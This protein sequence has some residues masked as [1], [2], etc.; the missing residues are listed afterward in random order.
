MT[1]SEF[2]LGSLDSSRSQSSWHLGINSS[3]THLRPTNDSNTTHDPKR[4]VE[5]AFHTTQKHPNSSQI[6]LKTAQGVCGLL[7]SLKSD[8]NFLRYWY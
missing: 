6:R 4:G 5:S 1:P 7:K 2:S 8:I 3:T